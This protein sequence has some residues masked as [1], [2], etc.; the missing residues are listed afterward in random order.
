MTTTNYDDLSIGQVQDRTAP[1]FDFVAPMVYP[2]HYPDDYLGLGD[3]NLSPYKVVYHAMKT[4]VDRMKSETTPMNGF[5]HERVGTSTPAVYQK[6]V[7]T[8]DRLRTWIQDFDYGG[9]YDIAEVRAQI[10]ASY[11]AGVMSFMIWAP[12]NIY[13]KGALKAPG[14]LEVSTSSVSNVAEQREGVG[15]NDVMED[16]T[17]RRFYAVRLEDEI[18]TPGN[19]SLIPYLKPKSVATAERKLSTLRRIDTYAV[20][21]LLPLAGFA[22][23]VSA[24]YLGVQ[25]LASVGSAPVPEV[26]LPASQE[27]DDSVLNY[28]IQVALSQPNFFAE[29]REAFVEAATTFIEADLTAMQLRFFENG[30][31]TESAPILAKGIEGTWWQTPAGLYAVE[32][33]KE[34]HFSTVGQVY[35]PWSLSFQGN[36]F[37]HGWP[38]FA[39]G[40]KVNEEFAGGGIRLSDVDAERL[41]KMVS[42]GT[43]VL[44]HAADVEA[45]DF[46]YEPKIP[47]LKT[48]H[49][50]IADVKSST[51]LASS[52]LDAVAPIASVAKLMTAL[53]AAEHINLDS[54]VYVNEPTFVQSLIPRLGERS[55]VSMY[56]LLQLLLVESSNEAAEVI[57]A[58]LGREEF[59][60]LINQKAS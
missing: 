2:S 4:G 30:V 60:A 36:F 48:P 43:P 19:G 53:V 55:K 31:L 41:Y 39:D 59:I 38:E 18:P 57:A 56:S 3:T 47:D 5:L 16:E 40:T 58:E 26:R 12:S 54:S 33:K 28:G 8:A 21:F 45:E 42:V 22:A 14:T 24:G 7:Y 32:F 51:V 11:D 23:V 37:I 27:G 6:P 15:Y 34:R 35:Q 10:Q 46:V 13:T 29:T 1:Y 52:D 49:Y 25:S 44:V 20:L 17:P 9:N 50:L